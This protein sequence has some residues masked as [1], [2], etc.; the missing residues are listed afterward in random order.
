M[1]TINI[2]NARDN[3]YKLVSQVGSTHLPILIKG[4]D[5]EAVLLSAEDWRSIEET[6]YLMRIPGMTDSM[7]NASAEPPDTYTEVDKAD[8]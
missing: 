5:S 3:L 7:K 4:K 8:W 1:D 6:L 2:T